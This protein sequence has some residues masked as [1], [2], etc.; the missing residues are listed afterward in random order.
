MSVNV[1]SGFI[2]K[3]ELLELYTIQINWILPYTNSQRILMWQLLINVRLG[4]HKFIKSF[5]KEIL[6]NYFILFIKCY[7]MHCMCNFLS[8]P[9]LSWSFYYIYTNLSICRRL[10]RVF[11]SHW[12]HNM[13]IKTSCFYTRRTRRQGYH[14]L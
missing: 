4:F 10:L 6:L 14:S 7:R 5:S 8:S 11:A 13:Y 12:I 3:E 2:V 1:K 9:F